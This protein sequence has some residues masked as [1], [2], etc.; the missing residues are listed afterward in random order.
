MVLDRVVGAA[1]QVFGDDGPLVLTGAV[2]DVQNELLF[3]TP[4]ILFDS[5]IQ[6]VVPSFTALF[7]YAAR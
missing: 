6:M 4:L 3:E 2:Q 5:R 7:T 1:L